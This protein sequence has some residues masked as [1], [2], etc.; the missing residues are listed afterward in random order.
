M[1]EL[2]RH[3]LERWECDDSPVLRRDL[4]RRWPRG[5]V[6]R[7]S[8]IGIV[9]AGPYAEFI[10]DDDC[11]FGCVIRAEF[12]REPGHANPVCVHRC[13]HGCGRVVLEA[14]EFDTLQ[15]DLVGLGSVVARACGAVGD[16]VEVVHDR[17]VSVGF[18]EHDAS[19]REVFV[20]VG[21][22]RSDGHHVLRTAARLQE[23]DS[24]IVLV[25]GGVPPRS[26]WPDGM[27]P[28]CLV[29]SKH[30]RGGK[31]ALAVT[32][33]P[34]LDQ[35]TVA[36]PRARSGQW[37]TNK[38]AT[39]EY[40]AEFPAARPEATKGVISRAC[41]EGVIETN[42]NTGA[43][44]RIRR[45]SFTTWLTKRRRDDLKEEDAP[46]GALAHARGRRSRGWTGPRA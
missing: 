31:R 9:R 28:V 11:E 14:R 32:L 5:D 40:C 43:R 12:E 20:A 18:I 3:L 2:L 29:L 25:T 16:V 19:S 21:L 44:L 42:G 23:A 1:L 6:D 8:E 30:V 27:K 38:E 37:M 4:I 7:L 33:G 34:A 24:P 22:G 26:V 35:A 46:A 17:M 13:L 41:R 10:R 45:T 39:A 15:L 36:H